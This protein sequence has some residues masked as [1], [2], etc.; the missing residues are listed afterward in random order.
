MEREWIWG[1][2]RDRETKRSGGKRNSDWSVLYKR[3]IYFQFLKRTKIIFE[4]NLKV[5]QC[6][7]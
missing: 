2:E 7:T 6:L 4:E 5:Y 3:R 1:R